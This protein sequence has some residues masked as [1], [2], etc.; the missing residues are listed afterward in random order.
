MTLQETKRVTVRVGVQTLELWTRA[1]RK[2]L[3]WNVQDWIAESCN[4]RAREL[5]SAE[6]DAEARS[7]RPRPAGPASMT[8]KGGRK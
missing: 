2:S 4:A 8:R 3:A 6:L 1:A 5:L 7:S